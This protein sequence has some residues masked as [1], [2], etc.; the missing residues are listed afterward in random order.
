MSIGL[1]VAW[2]IFGFIIGVI[3]IIGIACVVTDIREEKRNGKNK[4]S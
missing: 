2:F 4:E 3:T 1:C